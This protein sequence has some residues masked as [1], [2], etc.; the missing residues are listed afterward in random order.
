MN[1]TFNTPGVEENT[2]FLK[3]VEDAKAL[4]QRVN[5]CF[6]IASLPATTPE[7]RKQLLSFVVV[8]RWLVP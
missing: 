4:R 6:E 2:F 8:S 7:E 5:E 3:T 1:N